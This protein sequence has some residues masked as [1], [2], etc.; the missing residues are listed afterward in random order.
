MARIVLSVY[1]AF[2]SMR[3]MAFPHICDVVNTS[4]FEGEVDLD[5]EYDMCPSPFPLPPWPC[6]HVSY[7]LPKYFIEVVNHPRKTMFSGLWGVDFQLRFMN[8]GIFAAEA[9]NGS[10]SYHAHAIHIPF[11]Q[12]V[13]AGMACGGGIPDL[14]CFS[15]ASEHLGHNWRT[16][17]ADRKQPLFLAWASNPKMCLKKG[18]AV[19]ATGQ[20][21]L[22]DGGIEPMCSN[23]WI[24]KLPVYPPT[25]APVC[26]G[27]GIHF[28]RTGTVTSSDQ[29][30]ASLLI[31]S[32]IKSI[33]GSV[34]R[35]ISS[36][37]SDK[38]QM[39]YPHVTSSFKEGQNIAWLRGRGVNDIGRLRGRLDKYLYIVWQQQR[40]T[41]DAVTGTV[42][43]GWVR[44]V[45]QAC[46]GF[47]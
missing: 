15:A 29:T 19:S 22:T 21:A 4:Q 31:A 43:K 26:T 33:G 18:I 24:G 38:W 28:P 45:K 6:A 8:P 27:W 7:Y 37:P 44:L 32:R 35:S 16:G 42:S 23:S 1:L 13:L 9:D 3:A 11:A 25:D 12:E 39:F 5:V 17:W 2:Y 34:F 36:T 46:K 14:F 47:K 41:V 10:Y 40:C 20:W 30:T